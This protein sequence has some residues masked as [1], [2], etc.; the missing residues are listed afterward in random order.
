MSGEVGSSRRRYQERKKELYVA[1][2]LRMLRPVSQVTMVPC[3]ECSVE[4]IGNERPSARRCR[5]K[6]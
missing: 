5:R 2:N 4:K 1:G 6:L 3:R